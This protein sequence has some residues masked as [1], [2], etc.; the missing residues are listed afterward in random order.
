MEFSEGFYTRWLVSIQVMQLAWQSQHL[1]PGGRTLPR[2]N[3]QWQYEKWLRNSL[4]IGPAQGGSL[5]PP[6]VSESSGWQTRHSWSDAGPSQKSREFTLRR[7]I[8]IHYQEPCLPGFSCSSC[9]CWQAE[10]THTLT[11]YTAQDCKMQM[12]GPSLGMQR[13]PQV[14]LVGSHWGHN[15]PFQEP[16]MLLLHTPVHLLLHM[17]LLILVP[18]LSFQR[19]SF[20]RLYSLVRGAAPGHLF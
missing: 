17:P 10:G 14:P 16:S 3:P 9:R 20:F 19:R 13:N 1:S 11:C 15:V 8:P 5:S 7:T 4:S 18:T 12:V 6:T 2:T